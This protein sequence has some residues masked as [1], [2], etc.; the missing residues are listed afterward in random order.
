MKKILSLVLVLAM[1][2]A[3]LVSVTGCMAP[4]MPMLEYKISAG[5]WNYYDLGD[6]IT[7]TVRLGRDS[8]NFIGEGDLYVRIAESPYYE[9]TGSE[10]YRVENFHAF[11][12][13][14][15]N[16]YPLEFKF[17]IRVTEAS[18]V[19]VPVVI[20]MK[21]DY[22]KK[23]D[24]MVGNL[25]RTYFEGEEY[26]FRVSDLMF[27]SDDQGVIFTSSVSSDRS[28]SQQ[29]RPS[30]M[31]R[32]RIIAQSLRRQYKNGA[33]MEDMMDR[34]AYE[35]AE[36]GSLYRV[37]TTDD[38]PT[39]ISYISPNMRAKIYIKPGSDLENIITSGEDIDGQLIVSALLATLTENGN[40]TPA[41]SAAELI[42]AQAHGITK[43]TAPELKFTRYLGFDIPKGDDFYNHVVR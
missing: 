41:E 32:E 22:T 34:I 30:W 6:E 17:T 23:P 28:S 8:F 19:S 26:F 43:T 16:K 14:K 38:R 5:W 11:S 2:L 37:E 20:A 29:G 9:I 25:D 40:I 4:P 35:Q 42:Y 21:I 7:V 39:S 10:E 15:G 36:G 27:I 31:T 33:S 18:Y 24:Y 13:V 12:P 1:A 3:M